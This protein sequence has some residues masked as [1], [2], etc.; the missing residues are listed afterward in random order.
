[1]KT[2]RIPLIFSALAL[3]I[4]LTGAGAYAASQVNGSTIMNGS[5]GV[6]KLSPKAVKQLKGAKGDRGFRGLDGFDGVD[7]IDG[8]GT[9]GA[10]GASGANGAAGVAG[11]FD[12]AKVSY[13]AGPST[14]IFAGSTDGTLAATCP[15]GTKVISGGW[16][17]SVGYS[18]LSAPSTN[19]LTWQVWIDA[20]GAPT[21][22]GWA[23]A[24]CAAA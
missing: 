11:G 14:T 3:V 10:T 17:S 2:A 4:S 21:G 22:S 24:V 16:F 5:I 7:G 18:Y 1:M 8:V 23:Y 6:A 20:T 13:V 15:A 12:P 19:N 9:P